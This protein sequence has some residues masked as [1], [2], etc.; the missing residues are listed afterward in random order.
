[1]L[2]YDGS[3]FPDPVG[4]YGLVPPTGLPVYL[5]LP[6]GASYPPALGT[7]SVASGGTALGHVVYHGGDYVNPGP[8]APGSNGSPQDLGRLVL[9]TRR[10]IVLMPHAPLAPGRSYD[11][12]ITANGVV[13]A[14][15][16]ATAGSAQLVKPAALRMTR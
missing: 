5:Q 3:E 10:C 14:W 4:P 1:M 6:P 12:A 16:F 7:T 11:V 13:H 9:S 2:S 15:S 8:P